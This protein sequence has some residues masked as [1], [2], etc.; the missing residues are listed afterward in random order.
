M[1]SFEYI[2]KNWRMTVDEIAKIIEKYDELVQ[3]AL[4]AVDPGGGFY[5]SVDSADLPRL[6]I[7]GKNAALSWRKYESD[8]YGGGYNETEI[9]EFPAVLLAMSETDFKIFQTQIKSQIKQREENVR[10]AQEAV[11]R[12]RFE[13]NERATWARLRDK[14]GE[15]A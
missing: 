1:M 13:A 14:Y 8:Y 2:T 6:S 3:R 11:A 4:V 5:C 12:D 10:K 7:D 15:R 9:A